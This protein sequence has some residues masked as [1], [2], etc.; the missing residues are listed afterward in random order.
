MGEIIP[1]KGLKKQAN[2]TKFAKECSK[3]NIKFT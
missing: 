3:Q 1:S 2:V